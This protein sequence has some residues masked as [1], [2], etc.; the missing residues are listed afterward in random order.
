M[1]PSA[2]TGRLAARY[3]GLPEEMI[4]LSQLWQ[5]YVY[6]RQP[7]KASRASWRGCKRR[8]RSIPDSAFDGRL[9][10]HH[11]ELLGQLAARKSPSRPSRRL[12]PQPAAGK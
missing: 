7:E 3:Q 10:T 1:S 4:A 9:D 11:R 8:W 12:P 2:A 6:M 5:S